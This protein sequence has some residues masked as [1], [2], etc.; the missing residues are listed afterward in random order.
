LYHSLPIMMH[1]TRKRFHGKR[2]RP[3]LRPDLYFLLLIL[4]VSGLWCRRSTC[5]CCH[6]S[7]RRSWASSSSVVTRHVTLLKRSRR[8]KQQ[9][10][11]HDTSMISQSSRTST[12]S[13]SSSYNDND[14]D[15]K[16]FGVL[17]SG[18]RQSHLATTT[19]ATPS[20]ILWASPARASTKTKATATTTKRRGDFPDENDDEA[21]TFEHLGPVGKVVAG[22]IEI[23]VST[24]MEFLSG[25]VGGYILGTLTGIPAFVTKPAETAAASSSFWRQFHQRA[26]RMHTKSYQW[27]SS[28]GGISAAFGG[29]RVTTKVLR[30]GKEDEWSTIFSSMAA[31]A[32]F[33]RKGVYRMLCRVVS[34]VRVYRYRVYLSR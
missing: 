14:N 25:F 23:A 15:N 20:Q 13:S 6:A 22:S 34:C 27:G 21:A 11:G 33:A 12:S 16:R 5:T 32:Y 26:V 19:T 8:T 1:S 30:G 17:S 29:F 28:W 7:S 3:F 18:R 24:L 9:R 10:H 31:G 2:T 4:T